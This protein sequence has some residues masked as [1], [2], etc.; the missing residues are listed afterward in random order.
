[1]TATQRPAFKEQYVVSTTLV[2]QQNRHFE[3]SVRDFLVV[4]SSKFKMTEESK[5]KMI[6][7]SGA[8]LRWNGIQ[9]ISNKGERAEKK[10]LKNLHII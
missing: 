8:I 1:M 2:K 10:A 4:L 9:E 5:L 6:E 7:E 3:V